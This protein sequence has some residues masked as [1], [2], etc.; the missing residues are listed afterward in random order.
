MLNLNKSTISNLNVPEMSEKVG[1][2]KSYF[3]ACHGPTINC[4]SG[5]NNGNNSA[6]C[7]TA[8]GKNTCA[9]AC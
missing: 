4:G 2:I 7:P 8:Y 6:N 3:S 1:G 9:P 5:G